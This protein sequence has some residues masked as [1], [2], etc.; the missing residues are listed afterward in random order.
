MLPEQRGILS[1]LKSW[2]RGSKPTRAASKLVKPRRR[3]TQVEGL[4]DRRLLIATIYVDFGDEFGTETA[5]QADWRNFELD[6]PQNQVSWING[7]AFP[8]VGNPNITYTP[9]NLEQDFPIDLGPNFVGGPWEF[10]TGDE[11]PVSVEEA[12]EAR[13]VQTLQRIFAPFNVQVLQA[14]SANFGE[15]R[16]TLAG[17]NRLTDPYETL[18]EDPSDDMYLP[19]ADDGLVPPGFDP[20]RVDPVTGAPVG[21]RDTYIFVGGWTRAGNEVGEESGNFGF[22]M[23]SFLG[24]SFVD[25]ITRDPALTEMDP[26]FTGI[27]IAYSDGGGA[28]MADTIITEHL[29]GKSNV[30]TAVA[31][32]AAQLAGRNFGL[33][34]THKGEATQTNPFFDPDVN[35]LSGTDAMREGRYE[36]EDNQQPSLDEVAVFSRVPLM[37]G[38]LNQNPAL[39]QNAYDFLVN[40]VEVG[41]NTGTGL[42]STTLI[43]ANILYVTGTGASDRIKIAPDPADPLKAL[44]TVEAYRTAAMAPEDLITTFDYSLD[45]TLPP[46][47]LFNGLLIDAGRGD[48]QIEIDSTIAGLVGTNIEIFGGG[49]KDNISFSGTGAEDVNIVVANVDSFRFTQIERFLTQIQIGQFVAQLF[50]FNDDSTIHLENFNSVNYNVPQFLGANFSVTAQQGSNLAIPP[51]GTGVNMVID[52][53]A[54][55]TQASPQPIGVANVEFTNVTSVAILSA[56]GLTADTLSISSDLGFADGLQNFG[57]GLGPGADS[58]ILTGTNF[59]LPVPG[60]AFIFDG[61]VG[62]DT[63]SVKG[64][65]DWTLIDGDPV[66]PTDGMLICGGGGAITLVNMIGDNATIVTG[67]NHTIEIVSW[68]GIANVSSTGGNNTFIVGTPT[69]VVTGTVNATGGNGIET[70]EINNWTGSGIL[71]GGGGNDI[72]HINSLPGSGVT[73]RGGIGSDTFEIGASGS[74]VGVTGSPKIEGGDGNDIFQIEVPA[75]LSVAIDGGNNNDTFNI[76]SWLGTGSVDGGAGNDTFNVNSLTGSDISLGAGT[77]NDTFNLNSVGGLNTT[78]AGGD[79]IDTFNVK[80]WSGTG[81][82]SGGIGND[83][84]TVTNLTGN[85][86]IFGD[87][88]NDTFTVNGWSGSGSASGGAGNDAF[89]INDWS[90]TNGSAFGGDGDDVFNIKTLSATTTL[91]MDGGTGVDR[92][93]MDTW[94]GTGSVLGGA[95]ND[96]FQIKVLAGLTVA[97]DGGNDNDTFDINSWLGAGSVSG[98]AGNDTFNVNSLLSANFILNAGTGNDTINATGDTDWTLTDV[99]LIRGSGGAI[100]LQNMIGDTA[101]ITGGAGNNAIKID[102]W[103][104]LLTVNGLGGNDTFTIGTATTSVSGKLTALGGTG[105]DNFLLRGNANLTSRPDISGGTGIDAF[106][107]DDSLL[108]TEIDYVIHDFAIS[109]TLA[110]FAGVNLDTLENV[111]VNGSQGPNTFNVTPSL[112]VAFRVNGNGTVGGENVLNVD[113]TGTTDSKPTPGLAPPGPG[114][115]AWTFSSGH[116]PI[117]FTNIDSRTVPV[118]FPENEFLAIGSSQFK[119]STQFNGSKPLVRVYDAKTNALLFKFWAY[120]TSFT[121]GV[122]VA[123]ADITGD[124]VADIVAAPGPG[125]AGQVKVFDGRAL[126]TAASTTGTAQINPN[127]ALVGAFY[128]DGSAYKGGLY[129][130]AADVDGN[131]SVDVITST[132]TGAGKIRVFSFNGAAFVQSRNFTPYTAAEKVTTGAVVTTADVNGDGRAD[133]ITAPGGAGTAAIVKV[134]DGL[135]KANLRKFNGFEATFKNGVSIAAADLDGDGLAEIMVG[136]GSNGKSRVRVLNGLGQ[137]Q[138]EFNAFTSGNINAPL[139]LAIHAVDG[140]FELFVAQSTDT[141]S[142]S[143]RHFD[144]LTGALVDSFLENDMGLIGGVNLG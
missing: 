113:F 23:P 3:V 7:P 71:D 126:F 82:M 114:N 116:Q 46:L 17:N 57:A 134:F 128:S 11:L 120:E 37:V 43:Q 29:A 89:Q 51:A 83:V 112:A 92:F 136:A 74:S 103:S 138:R 94:T 90:G 53:T 9:F 27:P 55:P 15:V 129:I 93:E 8:Y 142:H 36:N 31:T 133:I 64:D 106:T 135:T 69:T 101:I 72:F 100:T 144:P 99:L 110:G 139:R 88:G 143:I 137:L 14:A 108:A 111:T 79:G 40:N 12:V 80:D 2:L 59:T 56:V 32:V 30:I 38:D 124:G 84:F 91:T 105:N 81:T 28:V 60:G 130:A 109:S 95:G 48:D 13:I 86:D 73:L 10:E 52:G 107:L 62:K 131:G 21:F 54:G 121:G 65:T 96:I 33:L 1:S 123:L 98:G 87:D 132:Q 122:R 4:E 102:S 35:V 118:G 140:Q 58:L 39:T 42:I 78:V 77:G 125:R 26:L 68:S 41:P 119:G 6:V 141:R 25:P 97:I 20:T 44:V 117:I 76:N 61:G 34:A 70:F 104:G 66:I 18:E 45:F 50:E 63:I 75:A 16:E 49:G 19:V 115:G 5:S 24:P 127:F 22:G 67:G 47:A 85:A